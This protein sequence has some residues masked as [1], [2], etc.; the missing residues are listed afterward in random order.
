MSTV[1]EDQRRIVAKMRYVSI[2]LLIMFLV[3]VC[4]AAL[5]VL[6]RNR[7]LLDERENR[8]RA[9]KS[10]AESEAKYRSIFENSVMGIFQSSPEGRVL[11]GN[12]AFSRIL[13]YASPE[14]MAE[15]LTDVTRQ[16]YVTPG[17]RAR[18]RGAL[19]QQGYVEGF[20][21]EFYRKDGTKVWAS[22]NARAVKDGDGK[23]AYYE[24]TV[25]NITERKRSEEALRTSR[26]QLSQA[27]RPRE[28]CLLGS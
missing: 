6:N 16:L 19:E 7:R 4:V 10:L 3:P 12:P 14:E 27:M 23:I 26:L 13:G 28:H 20:E 8:A 24:G 21:T 25:E 18:F 1:L 17:D 11:G 5:I 9:E 15:A 2:W 22:V